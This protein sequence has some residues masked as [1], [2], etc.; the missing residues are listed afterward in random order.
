VVEVN[1]RLPIEDVLPE[2]A[3]GLRGH[4]AV[5]LVAPTGAGKTTRV[6]PAL[7][8]AGL[9]GGKT[10]VVLEPRRLAARAAARR[11]A[12]ERGVELGGEVGYQVR[13]DRRASAATRLLVVTEGVLVRMLQD[14]PFLEQVG[15]VVFDEI[16][17]RS[18]DTDLALAMARRVQRDARPELKLVAMSATLA[19]AALARFLGDAP[20][21]ASE[22]RLFEV[23]TRFVE[24]EDDEWLEKRVVR[25]VAEVLD[26]TDG[27]VLVFLPGVGEIRR[28]GE[29]LGELARKRGLDLRELFGDLPPERQDAALSRGPRR[30]VV[31]ATNVAQTSVTVEGVTGVVDSGLAR[32]LRYDAGVGLDRLEVDWISR[33]SADQRRGRAGRTAPGVCLRLWTEAR[34]RSLAPE[35]EPEIARVD[36]AGA[37]LELAAWGERDAAQFGWYEAPPAAALERARE[38]L[39]ALGALERGAITRLGR[40]MARLPAPPRIARLLLAGAAEGHG[41]RVALAAALLAERD[42]FRRGGARRHVPAHSDVFERVLALEAFEARGHVHSDAGELAPAAAQGVLRARD[43]LARLVERRGGE[44]GEGFER[45]LERAVL[46][47]WPD[48]LAL[49]RGAGERRAVLVSGRGV[50][51]AEESAVVDPDWFVCVDTDAGKRGERAEALVRV[52]SGVRAEDL[53]SERLRTADELEFDARRERVVAMRRTRLDALLV[54]EVEVGV[55][56]GPEAERVLAEAAARDPQRALALDDENVAGFLARV[57]SLALW[58]PELELPRFDE[59]DLARVLAPLC[60]GRT[61][62]AALRHAAKC[63]ALRDVLAWEQA[64]ALERDAP[65]RIEVPSGSSVRL[66]YEPGRAPVLAVRLQELFGLRETPRVAGGRVRVLL[67]LLGPNFRPQQVTDDLASFWANTYPL[68]RAELRRR[69]PRH[70]WPEDPLAA[71]PVRGPKRRP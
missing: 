16:H 29:A 18:L 36:L 70:A 1:P 51:L 50:R 5:V 52:A 53:P 58:R 45:A 21:V 22:G 35:D 59:G 34:Q 27:D 49:R 71:E 26:A 28:A 3:S 42:P 46:R 23:E 24:R 32:V 33:A 48:R 67:H 2:V 15:A 66:A 65:E 37:V 13:F 19:P 55:E 54:R 40:D 69:Y 20:V 60:A 6:P 38:L 62:F 10:V 31:L 39:E 30:R 11:I 57:R 47:A 12:F 7:L 44:R 8:D 68:V 9:A 41:A 63:G 25:G 61:D 43:Q 64:A 56:A 14:D 17:E 4:G